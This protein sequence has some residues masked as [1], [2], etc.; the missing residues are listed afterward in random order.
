VTVCCQNLKLREKFTA[1]H[2]LVLTS[3]TGTP[4]SPDNV[5]ARRLKSIGKALDMP[6]L[7]RSV[8]RRTQ[9]TLKSSIGR[10]WLKELEGILPS[11]ATP[12]R[13]W[14]NIP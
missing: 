4:I 13:A 7:S 5:T 3:R 10:H 9:S 2:D 11:N 1:A 14:R 6:W 8:F 12:V